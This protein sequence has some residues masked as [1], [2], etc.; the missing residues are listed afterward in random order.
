MSQPWPASTELNPKMS[1]KKLRSASAFV[2]YRIT[3]APLIICA[4]SRTE[5]DCEK[6]VGVGLVVECRV[7]ECLTSERMFAKLF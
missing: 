2:L 1:L 7:N 6:G 4:K 3:C 5:E